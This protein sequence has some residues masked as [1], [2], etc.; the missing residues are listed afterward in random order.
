MVFAAS[1]FSLTLR[2]AFAVPMLFLAYLCFVM[3]NRTR[4]SFSYVGYMLATLSQTWLLLASL[5]GKHPSSRFFCLFRQMSWT[6]NG[7]IAIV[8]WGYLYQLPGIRKLI[9]DPYVHI[10][11]V[12]MHSLPILSEFKEV[13]T[14]GNVYAKGDYKWTILLLAGYGVVNY[15]DMIVHGTALYPMLTWKDPTSIVFIVF[16]IIVSFS[17]H[18]LGGFLSTHAVYAN[19]PIAADATVKTKGQ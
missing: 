12:F 15:V 11:M 4:W 6:F 16:A 9:S 5:L 8:F 19:K 1:F 13:C 3:D 17:L 18:C 10:L 7:I 14:N 2:L